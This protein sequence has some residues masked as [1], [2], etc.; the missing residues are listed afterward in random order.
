MINTGTV[1]EPFIYGYKIF[2]I[3]WSFQNVLSSQAS[4]DQAQPIFQENNF[5]HKNDNLFGNLQNIESKGI[6]NL[7]KIYLGIIQRVPL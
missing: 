2:K 3:Q 5:G 4:I 1:R 7:E 6:S